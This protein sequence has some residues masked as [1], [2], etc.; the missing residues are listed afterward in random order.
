MSAIFLE[1]S[2]LCH[3]GPDYTNECAIIELRMYLDNSSTVT[4]RGKY[5][6]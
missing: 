1:L 3:Y 4:R 2:D 5:R 6:V